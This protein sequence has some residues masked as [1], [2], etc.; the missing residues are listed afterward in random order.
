MSVRRWSIENL[1]SSY[2]MS[3]LPTGRHIPRKKWGQNFLKNPGVAD[4]IVDALRAEPGDLV[5][6]IGP[7]Q[8]MLTTR[9]VERDVRLIAFEIDRDLIAH[10]ERTLPPGKVEIRH[11][12]AT[13]EEL[14]AEP[15]AAIGNLP[16]NV[17]TPI[18]R[19][20]LANPHLKRALFMV[21]KEVA[22]RIVGK[23]GDEAYGFLSLVV[24][25]HASAKIVFT[26]EPGSFHPPPK[27]RSAVVL[28]EPRPASHQGST[29][30]IERLLMTSFQMRRKKLVNNLLTLEGWDRQRILSAI[31]DAGLS[32]NVRAEEMT[33][34]DFDRLNAAMR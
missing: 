1:L 2:I 6:E 5:L 10:L 23:V 9:L 26:L 22:D 29:A 31:R 18:I 14:P 21:Q 7:G 12:D 19:R 32:E 25:L 16:Y 24:Q 33:L 30:E 11:A 34:G 27:V 28:F 17:A 8:G 20:V 15:F 13:E 4:R 3:R